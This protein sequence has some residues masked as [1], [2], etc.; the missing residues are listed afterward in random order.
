MGHR[1]TV[2][3]GRDDIVRLVGQAHVRGGEQGMKSA[4]DLLDECNRKDTMQ[5]PFFT[6]KGWLTIMLAIAFTGGMLGAMYYAYVLSP[7][8][9]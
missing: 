4:G 6:V 3:P 2:V 7:F 5:L 1:A 9:K 8:T